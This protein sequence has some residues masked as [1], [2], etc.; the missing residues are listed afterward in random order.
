MHRCVLLWFPPLWRQRWVDG[1]PISDLRIVSSGGVSLPARRAVDVWAAVPVTQLHVASRFRRISRVGPGES[2]LLIAAKL[3]LLQGGRKQ[4]SA[5]IRGSKGSMVDTNPVKGTRDFPPEDMRL[6]NW[7]FGHFRDV[8]RAFGFEEID[9][10]VLESEELFTRKAG[11]L[12]REPRSRLHQGLQLP[13]P[14]QPRLLGLGP[15]G[16]DPNVQSLQERRSRISSTTL[17]TRAVGGWPCD[18]S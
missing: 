9:A 15:H 6:R 12:S 10:P 18:L 11:E 8:S 3:V 7:L 13:F 1:R 16:A 14:R 4:T 2:F 17:R 5:E